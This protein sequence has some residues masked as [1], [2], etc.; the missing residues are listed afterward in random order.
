MEDNYRQ[1]IQQ[2]Q[3][4]FMQDMPLEDVI[5]IVRL[6]KQL[7]PEDFDSEIFNDIMKQYQNQSI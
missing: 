6:Q 7:M 5:E 2:G 3:Y 1:T 4:G